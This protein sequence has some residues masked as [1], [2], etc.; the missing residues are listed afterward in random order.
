MELIIKELKNIEEVLLC[1]VNRKVIGQ[2]P[3]NYLQSHTVSMDE[4]DTITFVIYK[5]YTNNQNK[6]VMYNPIYDEVKEERFLNVDGDYYVIKKVEENVIDEVKTVTAYGQEKKLEK[7]NF[8]M[9]NL[10]LTLFEEDADEKNS[11]Y[12]F[13]KKLYNDVGWKLG[14]VAESVRYMEDGKPKTRIQ[15][16]TDTTYYNFITENIQDEFCCIPIFDKKNKILNLYDMDSFGDEIKLVLTKDNYVKSLMK[17][18]DSSDLV[19]RL[20]LQGNDEKCIVEDAT[21]TGYDYIENY[22]YF[23]QTGEMSE[24]LIKALFLFEKVTPDRIREWKELTKKRVQIYSNLSDKDANE[25]I[26][27]TTIEQLRAMINGYKEAETDGEKF[28]TTELESK[29]IASQEQ[30]NDLNYEIMELEEELEKLDTR[31]NELNLLCR[32]ETAKDFAG[33]L[34]FTP[35][36]LDELKEFTYYDTY[37]NDA[38]TDANEIIKTGEI[39]LDRRCKPTIEFSIN[40]VDFTNRIIM[41]HDRKQWKGHLG[42][43]D[44]ICLYD[45]EKKTEEFVY[46][47]SW[48]KNYEDESLALTFS[49]KK[50][51]SETARSIADILKTA[52]NNKKT[53]ASN[54]YIW[55]NQ[56]YNRVGDDLKFIYSENVDYEPPTIID[57]IPIEDISIQENS[58]Q[59]DVDESVSLTLNIT[60][61]NATNK[62][63]VWLSTNTSVATVKDGLVKGLKSGVCYVRVVSEDGA[64][65]A[66]C[67]INVGEYYE[68]PKDNVPIVSLS[69]L[70]GNIS[71]NINE[72]SFI[73]PIISPSNATNKTLT[74]K[75]SDESIAKVDSEGMVVGVKAGN[76]KITVISN[77]NPKIQADVLINVL[78][79]VNE[80]LSSFNN[81]LIIGSERVS[82]MN[83]FNLLSGMSV[84]VKENVDA[85]YFTND[86]IN[87]FPNNPGCVI[88]MLGIK[89]P[90]STGIKSMKDLLDKLQNKYPSKKIYVIKE[91]SVTSTVN[92]YKSINDQIKKF[93]DDIRS[94]S[95]A[96]GL[97]PLDCTYMLETGTLLNTA[98]SSD[99]INLNKLGSKLLYTNIKDNILKDINQ[100]NPKP[101]DPKPDD[102]KPV[103]V[104]YVTTASLNIR[105]GPSTEYDILGKFASGD[106]VFVYSI[107]NGWAKISYN[108]DIAYVSEKYI[109]KYTGDNE[110][111]KPDDPKPN[112]PKQLNDK[113]NKIISRAEDI[114]KLC[115]DGKA[116]YS[117]WW[118]TIDYNKKNTI[119]GDYETIQ[120]KT[121][122][123]P[124]KGKWGFD[125]SATVGC[126]YQ[127]AGYTFMQGL[128]CSQGTL[129]SMAKKHNAKAWRYKDDPNFTKAIPGDIVM[130]ANKG[131]NVTTSNMFTVTTH[132]TAIYAGD[133]YIIE[134]SGFTSGIRKIKRKLDNQ[135]F[136]FRIKELIDEDNKVGEQPPK[137]DNDNPGYAKTVRDKI[138]AKAKEICDLH[139]VKKQATYYADYAIFD[140][141]KRY[142]AKGTYN[143]IK[144]PYCYV[145]SSLSSCAYLYAGV[146]S[147][148]GWQNS[149]CSEGT[150]V[151][152]A[153]KKSGYVMKKLTS[154]TIND[155][156]PGDLLMISNGTVPSN[157]TVSWAS[158]PDGSNRKDKG[159]HHVLVYMGKENGSRMVAHASGNKEWPRAIRYEKM[160]DCYGSNYWYTHAF[161]LR[162]WDLAKLDKEASNKKPEIPSKPETPSKEEY[163]NCF[164]ETGVK[165]GNKYIYKFTKCKLTAYGKDAATASGQRPVAGKTCACH[166]MPYG[167]K[168]YIPALKGK[169]GSTGIFTCNDTGGMC[170]DFDLFLHQTSDTEAGRILSKTGITRAD[171]YVLEWGTGRIASSFTDMVKAVE[172]YAPPLSQ[173]KV[174]WK[175]YWEY[176]GQTINF[177]KFRNDDLNIKN[178]KYWDQL[179]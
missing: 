174:A 173:Y 140:D 4:I 112:D 84:K 75:S 85:T 11:V 45:K 97:I 40:S 104:K 6:T 76:C 35:E 55:N 13:E 51:K 160:F 178:T 63:V 108:N 21:A 83:S 132:H 89:N 109:K 53:I 95:N 128:S 88:V 179:K 65:T 158:A 48:T 20:K 156:L 7:N 149:N 69:V 148:T 37:T 81:A 154:V 27:N 175:S 42:L 87:G 130:W 64:H 78:T 164:N 110:D 50:T 119:K 33:N 131:Y 117:Q 116:W 18:G 90:S 2:I 171:V 144:N 25:T 137:D 31:I 9:S 15:E 61:E 43:G 91:L 41:K 129:Q 73:I 115:K 49:N 3:L 153:T 147:V 23:V 93:N 99:G 103:L 28:D 138:C 168:I 38:F 111:P 22:S 5:K 56:K 19:T 169:C 124:G 60:P 82:N 151:K 71:L 167:T 77:D 145:C 105:K 96:K 176:G 136:F 114:V 127:N 113:R 141:S 10:G 79:S 34:I 122:K 36:L 98:Y 165:D 125:C 101:D 107:T 94:Y 143:G 47:V 86:I 8:T 150:L 44:L 52:K 12:S 62:N 123:Q 133:G 92:G 46:F 118:R 100:D 155:L 16:N 120:G 163:P 142:R 70:K 161:I 59:I 162:P 29:M 134:A 146:T 68:A 106:T 72:E 54:R 126:A 24:E 177:T 1:K 139:Q 159:T 14:F 80:K 166:N 135:V 152:A 66:S 30:L 172:K 17:V 32:R 157:L 121:Y 26:L 102:P 170:F 74:Y 39:V 57:K 58:L 67:K